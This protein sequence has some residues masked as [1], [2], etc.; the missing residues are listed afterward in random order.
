MIWICPSLGDTHE[1]SHM[2]M[3]EMSAYHLFCIA[4]NATQLFYI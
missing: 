2:T 3:P 1:L 4:T